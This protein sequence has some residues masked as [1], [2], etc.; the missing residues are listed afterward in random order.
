M[1][2]QTPPPSS[3]GCVAANDLDASNFAIDEA[4]TPSSKLLILNCGTEQWP[5]VNKYVIQAVIL[6]ESQS[7]ICISLSSIS[8]SNRVLGSLYCKGTYL[9]G[10]PQLESGLCC[11]RLLD[12]A[13]NHDRKVTSVAWVSFSVFV[14]TA[15]NRPHRWAFE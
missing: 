8:D 13:Y 12:S 14:P 4:N 5:Q 2:D 3:V 10:M 1:I 9:N 6:I 7:T 11:K 15:T